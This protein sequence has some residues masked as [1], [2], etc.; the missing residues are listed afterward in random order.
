MHLVQ[1]LMHVVV[2]RCCAVSWPMALAPSSALRSLLSS[3]QQRL[4]LA[5]VHDKH[6]CFMHSMPHSSAV[7]WTCSQ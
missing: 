7:S 3:W 2:L 1:Q 5:G 4:R 6:S